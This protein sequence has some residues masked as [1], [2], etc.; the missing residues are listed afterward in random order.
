MLNHDQRSRLR[1]TKAMSGCSRQ[2]AL[3]ALEKNFWDTSMASEWI[4]R[5]KEDPTVSLE[6]F[7]AAYEKARSQSAKMPDDRYDLE[8]SGKANPNRRARRQAEKE[9]KNPKTR[10]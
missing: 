8:S 3:D 5:V 10:K 9:K 1:L 2:E 6:E 7:H 4:H